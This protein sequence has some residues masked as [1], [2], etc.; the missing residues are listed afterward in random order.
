MKV[1]IVED[2]VQ[3]LETMTRYLRTVGFVCEEAPSRAAAEEK[4]GVYDYDIVVLDITLPDG[5]GLDLLDALKKDHPATGVLI[6]SARNSLD[7]KLEGLDLGADDYI[8]KPFHLAE[9]NSRINAIIRR[10]SFHGETSIVF[11]EIVIDP[12]ARQTTVS[13]KP[14]DLTR[15]EYD[16]L[17]YLIT[18]RNRVLPKEAIAEHLWGDNIDMADNFDFIYTHIKNLRKKIKEAGGDDYL[19]T[20]Y[21]TGY[22]FT[23]R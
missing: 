18:N 3:L 23:D 8:T 11:N 12:S 19:H 15:K 5:S 21:G 1:L 17:L 10:R 6:V 13:G 2:E 16:L 22:T 20:V 9:L 14:L 7:D 4:L